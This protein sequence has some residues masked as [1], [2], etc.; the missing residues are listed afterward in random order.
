MLSFRKSKNE[1]VSFNTFVPDTAEKDRRI[2]DLERDLARSRDEV[3]QLQVQLQTQ[4]GVIANLDRFGTSLA[5]VQGGLANL[6]TT[7]EAEHGRVQTAKTYADTSFGTVTTIASNLVE[8]AEK[9]ISTSDQVGALDASAQKIGGIVQL[10]REIAEQTNLLAL[11]AAIEAARAGEQG[12]GFAVV[13]DEVR[14][15][16]ERTS[17][18]TNDVEQ[19]IGQI[20]EQSTASRNQMTQFAERSREFS[21]DGQAAAESVGALQGLSVEMEHSMAPTALKSFVELAKMD[22]LIYKFEVYR[23]L[24]GLNNK[25]AADFADHHNC[26]LG[27]WYYQ[28]EGKAHCSHLGG[29][30]ELET[31]HRQFHEQAISAVKAYANG[32]PDGVLQGVRAMEEQSMQVMAQLDKMA[33][34]RGHHQ[35]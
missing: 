22:H 32:H 8:L 5:E 2:S 1:P 30:R 29:F 16:A 28:G 33:I 25:T 20:R 35:H 3:A 14:K 11:N 27:K 17:T 4:V 9:S 6:S 31:P 21:T 7:I 12:R 10:I 15:L 19:L 24:F 34:A 26:R 23:V 18:A 13:A